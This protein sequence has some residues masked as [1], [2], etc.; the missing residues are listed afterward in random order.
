MG[1]KPSLLRLSLPG[2][3]NWIP[4]YWIEFPL[5]YVLRIS[6]HLLLYSHRTAVYVELFQS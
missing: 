5:E 6:T 2:L 3:V 4:Q 1:F